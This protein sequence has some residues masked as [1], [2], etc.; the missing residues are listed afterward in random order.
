[1]YLFE[2]DKTLSG[3]SRFF[4]IYSGMEIFLFF[5][6]QVGEVVVVVV[7]DYYKINADIV[8]HHVLISSL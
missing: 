3:D 2:A 8:L 5:T 6:M 4:Y 1:M 7:V